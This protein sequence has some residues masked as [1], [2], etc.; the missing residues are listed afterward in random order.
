M[1]GLAINIRGIEMR[2]VLIGLLCNLVL[3]GCAS[4]S[5]GGSSFSSGPVQGQNRDSGDH[6]GGRG[7]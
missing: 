3:Q 6:G 1:V 2:Y 7:R 5:G 4:S